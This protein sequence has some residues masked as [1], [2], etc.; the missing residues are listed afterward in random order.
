MRYLDLT[1]Q[2]INGLY[3]VRP[4]NNTEL[5][6]LNSYRII[7]TM[8]SSRLDKHGTHQ[9]WSC[10]CIR[11]GTDHIVRSDNRKTK[12]CKCKKEIK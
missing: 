12:Q 3:Y 7:S 10:Y 2:I 8:Y 11:C 1:D 6:R 5:S 9:Y 4:A